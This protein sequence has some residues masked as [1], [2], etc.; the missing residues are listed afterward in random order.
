MIHDDDPAYLAMLL[1]YLGVSGYLST[2]APN[3]RQRSVDFR[4]WATFARVQ[5]ARRR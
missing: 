5:V 3:V 1:R 4:T 2:Q